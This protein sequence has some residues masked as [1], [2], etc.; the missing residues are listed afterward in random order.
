[1]ETRILLPKQLQLQFITQN[2][3]VQ[4][5]KKK[6]KPKNSKEKPTSSSGCGDSEI[7]DSDSDFEIFPEKENSTDSEAEGGE[8]NSGIWNPSYNLRKKGKGPVGIHNNRG[9]TSGGI[10]VANADSNVQTEQGGVS[11]GNL[12][13]FSDFRISARTTI[14]KGTVLS[15]NEGEV[16]VVFLKEVP[17]IKKDDVSFFFPLFY[18]I[19]SP[20]KKYKNLLE[21]LFFLII[22]TS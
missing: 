21:D 3:S 19:L 8:E 11:G 6:R 22:S 5:E 13:H 18:V 9:E 12:G 7:S 15:G 2:N 14:E 17:A 10:V 4:K 1:M 16:C 20:S